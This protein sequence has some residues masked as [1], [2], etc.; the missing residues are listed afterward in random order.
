MK[1]ALDSFEAAVKL[2]NERE[3]RVATALGDNE[4]DLWKSFKKKN[5]AS[6]NEHITEVERMIRVIAKQF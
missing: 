4:F 2:H 1:G 5:P 6:A 3:L